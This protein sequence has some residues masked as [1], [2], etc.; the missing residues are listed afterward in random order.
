MKTV[1]VAITAGGNKKK[2]WMNSLRERKR[3]RGRRRERPRSGSAGH[4]CPGSIS[5]CV[6]VG[7]G[8]AAKTGKDHCFTCQFMPTFLPKE[9]KTTEHARE[10][11]VESIS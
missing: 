10:D 8:E 3:E 4:P 1:G 5:A 6:L 2:D 11:G 7:V 9:V